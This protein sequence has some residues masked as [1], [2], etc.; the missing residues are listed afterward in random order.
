MISQNLKLGSLF[1]GVG[2]FDLGAE[3]EGIETVWNCEIEPYNIDVL[4]RRF[5]NTYTYKNI[6]EMESAPPYVDIISGGFPCQDISIANVS[7][8]Q[9]WSNGNIGI[10]GE[11]S[12]LWVEMWRIINGVRPPYVI[13]ENSP[14][15]LHRGLSTIISD[16]S[17]IGYVLE[18]Q[19]LS[20]KAFG[21]N[22]QRE[23]FF[24]IAYPLEKRCKNNTS[25]FQ[26][27]PKVLP[28]RPPRQIGL[29]MPIERFNA[30]SNYND[31]RLHDG[32]SRQ[33]DIKAIEAYG[34][35]VVVDIASYLFYCIK[36]HHTP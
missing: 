28:K 1:S 32:F 7:N 24:G 10:Q 34:N 17:K 6:M 11:R 12:G 16:L 8:K 15:L 33:L 23:R 3:L 2:G 5:P 20:A 14:M 27:I 25:V 19:C 35:A 22:H 36:K 29:S 21:Y 26:P 31:V 4:N 30:T 13:I 18:W 9:L